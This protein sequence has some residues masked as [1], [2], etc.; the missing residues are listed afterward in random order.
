MMKKKPKPVEEK[1]RVR[2]P[3]R[4]ELSRVID[5]PREFVFKAW[6]K[7]HPDK[8]GYRELVPPERL[9][10]TM[11]CSDYPAEW[12]ARLSRRL[13]RKTGGK[14]L[15]TVVVAAVF[16][17]ANG[18]TKLTIRTRFE[19]AA[20]RDALLELGMREGWARALERL[21][22]A[23]AQSAADREIVAT[24]VFDAPRERV[25]AA[26]TDRRSVAR[27]WAPAGFV[28]TI[29]EL[30][31]RPG[32]AWRFDLRGPDGAVQA[33]EVAFLEVVKPERLVFDHVSEPKYHVQAVFEEQGR[34]TKATLRIRFATAAELAAAVEKF[35][36]VEGA[37]QILQRLAER[38]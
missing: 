11:D 26:W 5:A 9:V 35:G 3:A 23:L 22:E 15:G 1:P 14:P 12:H 33:H 36:A 17:D 4:F 8:G 21:D 18:K 6:L 13:G 24:R 19:S 27:W 28:N 30:D 10:M 16:D 34:R 37:R 20:I 2:G 7:R 31:A 29:H 38:L 25:F 32:G